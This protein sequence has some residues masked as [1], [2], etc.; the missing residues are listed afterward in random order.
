MLCRL[1]LTTGLRAS[2]VGQ[3]DQRSFDWIPPRPP[4]PWRRRIRSTGV[5]TCFP[6]STWPN[7]SENYLRT[8]G[9]CPAERLWPGKLVAKASAKM[10][11]QDLGAAEISY[12][13]EAGR[14]FYF[15]A[16]GATN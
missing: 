7:S 10:L 2:E 1:A 16:V 11:R 12:E 9:K 5:G 13:D 6:S 14:V 4:W 3:S 8:A 15:D